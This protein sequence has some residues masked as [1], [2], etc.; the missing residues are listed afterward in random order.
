MEPTQF[1]QYIQ[2]YAPK[3]LLE[4]T[5]YLNDTLRENAYYHQRF[6]TP[7]YSVTGSWEVINEYNKAIAADVIALDSSIPLKSNPTIETYGGE[8]PKVATERALN[9][10]DLRKLRLMEKSN[11]PLSSI[12]SINLY[13]MLCF[14]NVS[15]AITQLVQPLDFP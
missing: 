5:K 14:S 13:S 4:V 15:L 1:L 7:K 3:L 2:Q 9:E 11:A 8:I 6:L 12:T 10:S